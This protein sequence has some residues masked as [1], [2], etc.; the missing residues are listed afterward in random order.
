MTESGNIAKVVRPRPSNTSVSSFCFLAAL[1]VSAGSVSADYPLDPFRGYDSPNTTS[2]AIS[3]DERVDIEYHGFGSSPHTIHREYNVV[4]LAGFFDGPSSQSSALGVSENEP[5]GVDNSINDAVRSRSNYVSGYWWSLATSE[6]AEL[7]GSSI[8][9]ERR[10]SGNNS[11][12]GVLTGSVNQNIGFF[13]HGSLSVADEQ[14]SFAVPTGNAKGK[15]LVRDVSFG[16]SALWRFARNRI[17]VR[18]GA[19]QTWGGGEFTVSRKFAENGNLI[20]ATLINDVKRRHRTGYFSSIDLRLTN[21]LLVTAFG[22]TGSSSQ[23]GVRLAL[24]F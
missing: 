14:V 5:D 3:I 8:L 17:S 13:L 1:F 2:V 19:E 11:E 9:N 23:A 22:S 24:N 6:E 7:E 21:Q 4:S 15:V 20:N 16:V 10:L 18:I 12:V